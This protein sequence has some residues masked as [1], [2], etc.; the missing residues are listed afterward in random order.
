MRKPLYNCGLRG[1]ILWER[2]S[3][4]S[5]A[6]LCWRENEKELGVVVR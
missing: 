3:D 6:R 5:P 1:V 4:E 2:V